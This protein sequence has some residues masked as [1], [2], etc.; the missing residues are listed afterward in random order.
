VAKVMATL[1]FVED[2]VARL[3]QIWQHIER[4]SP[5][6]SDEGRAGFRAE[7]S[8]PKLPGDEGHS[9]QDDI[10]ALFGRA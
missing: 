1:R 4:F 2:H 10:D 7:L 6:I 9:T 3:L 5:A 8:G